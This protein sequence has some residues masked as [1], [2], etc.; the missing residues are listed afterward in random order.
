MST[1]TATAGVAE[2]LLQE[3]YGPGAWHGADLK[4][5]IAEVS[6]KLAFWR[7]GERRHN[8]AEIALHH[9]YY[10]HSVRG[11]LL[12]KPIEA[13]V[14]EGDDWFALNDENAM[15]WATVF[16]TV[17]EQQRKLA[18]A[19]ADIA[20]DGTLSK[21]GPQEQ[22]DLVIGITCHAIYHAGQIQLIKVLSEKS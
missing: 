10:A 3:S 18:S 6:P 21:L 17:E 9:A 22:L 12:A 8:I 13:F 20:R 5:A 2:R 1:A 15:P 19:L 16:T 14:R 7:P 4:A 11:R